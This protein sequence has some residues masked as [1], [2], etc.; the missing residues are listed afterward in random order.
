MKPTAGKAYRVHF[1]GLLVQRPGKTDAVVEGPTPFGCGVRTVFVERVGHKWTR[2]ICPHTLRGATIATR[3]LEY[4]L[5]G[6]QSKEADTEYC[7]LLMEEKRVQMDAALALAQRMNKRAERRGLDRSCYVT[8][9]YTP[10]NYVRAA[11]TKALE[12]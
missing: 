4:L 3:D 8:L 2:L 6:C 5:D 9:P 11:I 7:V 1:G 12:E 10:P